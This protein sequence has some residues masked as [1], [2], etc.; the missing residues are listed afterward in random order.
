MKKLTLFSLVA[1]AT[2]FLSGCQFIQ[3]LMSEESLLYGQWNVVKIYDGEL[4]LNYA[5]TRYSMVF[6]KKG[7][8]KFQVWE[9]EGNTNMM[10]A[11]YTGSY[12]YDQ[13]K[14]ILNIHFPIDGLLQGKK[15]FS[16]YIITQFQVKEL[17]LK[18]LLL[19][20]IEED[21]LA[22]FHLDSTWEMNKKS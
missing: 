2:I 5:E 10:I 18:R 6:E 3:D 21:E 17:T 4:E 7:I 19:E 9:K 22:I 8:F 20:V 12:T 13:N 14:Y 11:N 15:D 1:T 16:T